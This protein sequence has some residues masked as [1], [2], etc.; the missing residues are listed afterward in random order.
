[1]NSE[2]LE[3]L[4]LKAQRKRIDAGID[5]QI[6]AIE[7]KQAEIKRLQESIEVSKKTLIELDQKIA[8][9]QRKLGHQ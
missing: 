7:E 8:E 3:L 4:K 2:E 6:I 5:D 9:F 1:M